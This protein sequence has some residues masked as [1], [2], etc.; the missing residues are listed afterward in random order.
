MNAQDT[1]AVLTTQPATPTSGT[2]TAHPSHKN[3]AAKHA[4]GIKNQ[5]LMFMAVRSLTPAEALGF[6]ENLILSNAESRCWP[7]ISDQKKYEHTPTLD[8]SLI[9]YWQLLLVE[10]FLSDPHSDHPDYEH[11]ASHA[12]SMIDKIDSKIRPGE[13]NDDDVA[14][15]IEK[16]V[17]LFIY[18]LLLITPSEVVVGYW[19]RLMTYADRRYG[20]TLFGAVLR[21]IKDG[22]GLFGIPKTHMFSLVTKL[23]SITHDPIRGQVFKAVWGNVI[24]TKT[25]EGISWAKLL[26]PVVAIRENPA[27]SDIA[28]DV[29]ETCSRAVERICTFA[30][31]I[32]EA[33]RI[34]SQLQIPITDNGI[35]INQYAENCILNEILVTLNMDHGLFLNKSPSEQTRLVKSCA[36]QIK[37]TLIDWAR[38]HSIPDFRLVVIVRDKIRIIS[39]IRGS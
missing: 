17:D 30:S 11:V 27:I 12:I 10:V 33:L 34:L 20:T 4:F 36:A 15:V 3:A 22:S 6:I 8:H 16:M 19:Q 18:N 35:T 25:G 39:Q 38:K 9:V 26:S 32:R 37:A 13:E 5:T 7:M 24:R 28:Y 1:T 2:K 29:T 23:I 31:A 14:E 21:G